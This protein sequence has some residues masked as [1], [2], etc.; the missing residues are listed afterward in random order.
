MD[1]GRHRGKF[2]A[3]VVVPNSGIYYSD[4]FDTS[5][6][7]EEEMDRIGANEGPMRLYI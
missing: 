1:R 2:R 6:E 3:F 7:A 4:P 5:E